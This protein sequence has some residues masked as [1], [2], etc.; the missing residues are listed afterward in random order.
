[1][2]DDNGDSI[3]DLNCVSLEV[4]GR[5]Q[6]LLWRPIAKAWEELE[7][8]QQGRFRRIM[9]MW[10]QGHK[11]TQEMFNGNEGRSPVCNVMLQA[12][13]AFKIRIY[14]FVIN[15][16]NIRSFIVIDMDLAKKQDKADQGILKRAYTRLDE[17]SKKRKK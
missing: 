3:D 11:L 2:S 13:K 6:V 17:M 14:G 5:S 8:R 15:I 9:Q 1:M 4:S 10:C 7:N 12:F 16:D